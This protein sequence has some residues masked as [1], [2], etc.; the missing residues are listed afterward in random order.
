M[1]F[2]GAES[3]RLQV[4]VLTPLRQ[5]VEGA[6]IRVLRR[7]IGA[8]GATGM[9]ATLQPKVLPPGGYLLEVAL[10]DPVSGE[11]VS[12]ARRFVVEEGS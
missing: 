7:F 6:K 1:Y 10:V 5:A 2:P 4:R 11:R 3:P 8:D 9:V 12:S